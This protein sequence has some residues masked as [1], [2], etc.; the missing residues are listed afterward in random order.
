MSSLSSAGARKV[1][2]IAAT[3]FSLVGAAERLLNIEIYSVVR[4]LGPV[5]ST[6][7]VVNR[8]LDVVFPFLLKF[9]LS[10][11]KSLHL[12]TE[13]VADCLR[14]FGLHQVLLAG[15]Q[16]VGLELGKLDN[17]TDLVIES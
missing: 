14:R 1:C 6:G 8:N 2:I 10:A 11:D 16:R 7:R 4:D 3:E 12:P 5:P 15:V 17:Q 13:I 9:R